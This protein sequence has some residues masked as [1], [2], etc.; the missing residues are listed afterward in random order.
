MANFRDKLARFMSGRY[1]VD[2]LYYGLMA[3]YFV[4]LVARAFIR[5]SVVDILMWM[6][7]IGMIFRPLSRN[8]YQRRRENEQFLKIWNRIKAK[9]AL[10]IR[11]IKEFKTRRFRRCP[12]CKTVLR[13][14]RKT[15]KH[16][17]ECPCCHHE[18]KVRI[19][20]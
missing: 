8:V 3:V 9:S 2:Q 7:L 6:V 14:P 16:T 4:L 15:G 10:T 11:R 20:I 13:L 1:G 12:H 17:V 19:F 5:W 18:F